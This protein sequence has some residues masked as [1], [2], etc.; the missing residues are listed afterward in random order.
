MK[1]KFLEPEKRI[2]L[3]FHILT[4]TKG[5]YITQNVVLNN[6]KS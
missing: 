4:Q 1:L 3:I 5:K 6:V 2:Q